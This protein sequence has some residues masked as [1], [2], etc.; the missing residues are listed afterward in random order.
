MKRNIKI[1]E[2]YK[3]TFNL[4]LRAKYKMYQLQNL[5]INKKLLYLFHFKYNY[6]P[7]NIF[8]IITKNMYKINNKVL[9]RNK[10]H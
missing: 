9:I 6:S 8:R 3:F 2:I 5:I 4:S 7:T 1:T 10:Q